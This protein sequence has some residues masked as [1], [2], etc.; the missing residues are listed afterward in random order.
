[1]WEGTILSQVTT[2]YEL[3]T[4]IIIKLIRNFNDLNLRKGTFF[5]KIGEIVYHDS[6]KQN[7]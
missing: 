5:L 2:E 3:V 4:G 1:M 7:V 6:C